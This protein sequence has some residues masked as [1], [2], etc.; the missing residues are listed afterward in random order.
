M[1][2]LLVC[3]FA[4]FSA[5]VDD[6]AIPAERILA[7]LE[8]NERL[9]QNLEVRWHEEFKQETRPIGKGTVKNEQIDG[10]SIRQARWHLLE[11]GGS[12]TLWAA[13]A[14][15]PKKI[16]NTSGFDGEVLRLVE[17]RGSYVANISDEDKYS[18]HM[19][20]PHEVPL[21]HAMKRI[22][23]S[24]WLRGK[25]AVLSHPYGDPSEYA[26]GRETKVSYVGDE[27]ISGLRCARLLLVSTKPNGEKRQQESGH[28]DVWLAYERNFLPVK[29][30]TYSHFY[31]KELPIE[32]SSLM[33]FKE[34]KPGVWFPFASKIVVYDEISL[35]EDQE[36]KILSERDFTVKSVDLNP[37]YPV[38]L[39]RN[40]F[41]PDGAAVYRVVAGEIVESY[42]QGKQPRV[43]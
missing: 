26:G 17:H 10:R 42:I 13:G 24:T 39:F 36:V 15:P 34:I 32:E 28:R 41:F 27:V 29:L 38:E 11:Y 35:L 19:F 21:R 37:G 14:E 25:D 1:E 12:R 23:L 43:E 30:V 6:E 5:A 4:M 20:S 31:S 3:L 16:D 33:D 9:Y 22:P 40:I 7:S 2:V 8:E 18:Y